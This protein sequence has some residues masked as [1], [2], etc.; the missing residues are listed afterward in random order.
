MI[1]KKVIKY[2]YKNRQQPPPLKFHPVTVSSV[3]YISTRRNKWGGK[4]RI[5][6]TK[7]W[8]SGSAGYPWRAKQCGVIHLLSESPIQT[9][10]D[11]LWILFPIIFF[12]CWNTTWEVPVVCS[13]TDVLWLPPP[14]QGHHLTEGKE[15]AVVW[16]SRDGWQQREGTSL[17]SVG[18]KA[19]ATLSSS[20][21]AHNSHIQP[22]K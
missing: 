5:D 7:L 21:T 12:W 13:F 10:S 2:T 4:R 22:F 8:L 18:N 6:P 19:R 9:L 20:K 14:E 17:T 16:G 11:F 3:F 15:Y 1:I